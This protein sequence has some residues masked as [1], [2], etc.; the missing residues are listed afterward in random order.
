MAGGKGTRLRPLTCGR[1]KPMVPVI[2]RPMM[3]HIIMLLKRHNITDI[4]STLFYMPEVI[5]EYFGDGTEF[6][7]NMSYFV[8]ETP[9]G[10]AGSVKNAEK[11]LDDTFLVI[12]GDAL[13]DINLQEAI[14]FHRLKGAIATIILTRVKT[15]LEYG[16]VITEEDGRIKQFLEK[17]GWSQVFSDTVNTGIYILEPEV[18]SLF[19]KGEPFDFSK[20]LFPILLKKGA[21]LY[22]YVSTG[23]WSDI[24]NIDQYRESHYDFLNGKIDLPLD[25]IQIQRGVW[26]GNNVVISGDVEIEG[27]VWI[28][29]NV[30][31]KKGTRISSHNVIGNNVIIDERSTVKRSIIWNDTYVGREVQLSGA[32]ACSHVSIKN[33]SVAYEGAV[34]G[35]ESSI[36]DESIIKPNIKI[37]PCK[38]VDSGTILTTSLVWSGKWCKRIF[39]K[40]GVSGIANVEITPDF[41]AKLGAAYCGTL[42]QPHGQIVASSDNGRISQ[43]IKDSIT[44]GILSGGA[45]V[46]DIGTMPTPVTRYAITLFQAIG[47]INIRLSPYDPNFLIIEFLDSKGLNI[48]KG[49]ERSIE[50]NFFREDFKR[51]DPDKVGAFSFFSNILERYLSDLLESIDVDSIRRAQ[52]SIVIDYCSRNLSLLLPQFLEKM[53]CNVVAIG[54]NSSDLAPGSISDMLDAVSEISKMVV[55]KKAHVGIVVDSNAEKFILIDEFGNIVPE[56]DLYALMALIM[57]KSSASRTAAVPVTAPGIIER[58]AQRYDGRVVRTKADGRSIMETVIEEKI[59][60]GQRALPGFQPVSDGLLSFAKILELMAIEGKGLAYFIAEVPDCHMVRKDIYCPWDSKGKVMRSLIQEANT[61]QLELI[62]GVKIKHKDGWALILPDSEKPVFHLYSE[63]L[64]QETA[65]E[66]GKIYSNKIDN[67]K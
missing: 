14:A 31:I 9:L 8:E 66:L 45:N 4:C 46:T 22:G 32:T 47:G 35:D 11:S 57:L 21:P 10:T 53:G 59:F 56:E 48:S 23:Y 65:E 3:E 30:R 1:P 41:A 52:F 16:I 60:L 15:P 25:G 50:N 51:V 64:S 5:K 34:I 2:N 55:E 33:R 28:G 40:H 13:T 63:G 20:D 39:G 26:L 62:D 6:N 17:P 29:N 36:G 42:A 44:A 37:W 49:E 67:F 58:L 38:I 27:P 43:I 54:S 7:V 12:S 61:A 19:D 18:L 24:G